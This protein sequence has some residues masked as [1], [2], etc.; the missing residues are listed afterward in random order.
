MLLPSLL[1]LALVFSL[2]LSA[3]VAVASATVH[4]PDGRSSSHLAVDIS[5]AASTM[6]LNTPE[7]GVTPMIA[8]GSSHTVGL[9]YDGTVVA[10]GDN[11]HGPCD[12]DG[13]DRN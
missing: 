4:L 5:T 8:A 9:K 10:V 7:G 13:W 3:S 11:Y 1:S 2:I 6:A 12:V